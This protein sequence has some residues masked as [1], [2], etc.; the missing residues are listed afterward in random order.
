MTLTPRQH[1]TRS[2]GVGSS[3]IAMLI[4][5]ESGQP[6]SPYGGP[7]TLWRRKMGL[8]PDQEATGAMERGTRFEPVIAQWWADARGYTIKRPTTLRHKDHPYCVDSCDFIAYDGKAIKE[9]AR[10]CVEVKAITP[11][12][13]HQWGEPGTDQLP[14]IY[15][16]QGQWHMEH[17]ALPWC[18]YP[19]DTGWDRQDYVLQ[20]DRELFLALAAI[21]EKF[22][23]DH[24]EGEKEPPADGHDS[25][26]KWLARRI[27]VERD[28][29]VEAPPEIVAKMLD[30]RECALEAKALKGRIDLLENEIKQAVGDAAGLYVPGTK[31]RI[32]Y[33]ERQGR[34][35][36]AW[37]ALL[38][39]LWGESDEAKARLAQ[40]KQEF[41]RR[42]KPYRQLDKR[43]LLG[44]GGADQ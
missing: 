3:E 30:L 10:G 5:D 42:G 41:T 23:R 39:S 15:A 25:T 29:I 8:D 37:D 1:K 20:R 36:V 18:E 4:I 19:V 27:A 6:L 33:K 16:V 7:H 40:M 38:L 35:F 31:Q 34:S 22:W 2:K 24:I 32:T 14:A 9:N 43:S 26:S 21:A 12:N 17:H 13:R 28:E 44:N 11:T